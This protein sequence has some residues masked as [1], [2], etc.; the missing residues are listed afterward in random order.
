MMRLLVSVRDASEALV[1]ARGG[2]DFIDAKEPGRGALGD[3][4]LSTIHD[5]VDRLRDKSPVTAAPEP[6]AEAAPAA[7]TQAP[8]KSPSRIP[9]ARIA[10]TTPP[11]WHRARISGSLQRAATMRR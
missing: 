3:L 10:V 8:S 6:A 9:C 2:A 1:A 11:S 5:I 4:P 7:E